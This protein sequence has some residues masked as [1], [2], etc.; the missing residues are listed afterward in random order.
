MNPSPTESLL[1][2]IVGRPA[3]RPPRRGKTH[4]L[5]SKAKRGGKAKL[6]AGHARPLPWR[7]VAELIPQNKK[8][9]ACAAAFLFLYSN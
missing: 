5:Q 1:R 8:A 6:R 3:L 7:P 9:T 2:E 4:S